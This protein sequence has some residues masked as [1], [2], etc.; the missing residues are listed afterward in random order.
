MLMSRRQ[1]WSEMHRLRDEMDR[2]FGRYGL[3]NGRRSVDVFPPVNL[4]EDADNLY[5]EA[6][7]PGFDLSDLE[8]FVTGGNQLSVKGGRKRPEHEGGTWHREE[9]GYGNFSRV[10]ELPGNVDSD[11]VSAEFRAGVLTMTLPKSEEL[12]PR[13][14]EVK[15]N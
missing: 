13:R 12:K 5:V 15:G 9:R 14:I 6:E 4:W 3:G 7:L 10:I 1:P 11:K 8:I 2:L